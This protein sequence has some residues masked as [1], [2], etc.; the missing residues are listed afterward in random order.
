MKKTD[1]LKIL[2]L[3]LLLC[4]GGG[5]LMGFLTQTGVKTW[6]PDLIKP[7]ATPPS[8][9]FPLIWT[10]LYI[11]MATSLALLFSSNTKNKS[12][13][14]VYFFIQLFLNFLWPVLFFYWQSPALALV[15][16][17][18]LWLFLYASITSFWKHMPLASILLW[19]YL[20]WVSYAAYL[21][22]FILVYN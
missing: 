6:Y 20:V 4:L 17:A 12:E 19:P 10:I 8:I 13:A 11:L 22:L 2:P 5:W 18:L 1:F 9:L 7:F 16:I 3:T 14:Y 15:D 21:N